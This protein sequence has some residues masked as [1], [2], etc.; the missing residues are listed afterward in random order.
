MLLHMKFISRLPLCSVFA[1]TACGGLGLPGL[2]PAAKAGAS[3]PPIYGPYKLVGEPLIKLP[4]DDPVGRRELRIQTSI[5]VPPDRGTI[6]V[7]I[8]AHGGT[9]DAAAGQMRK[10]FDDL[11]KAA[12]ADKSCSAKI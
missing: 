12:S 2:S 11:K 8:L 9:F 10:A 1:L 7:Q 5:E 3:V 4:G 6:G